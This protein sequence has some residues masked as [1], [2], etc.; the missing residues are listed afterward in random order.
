MIQVTH[1]KHD[2]TSTANT[3]LSN[4]SE[5]TNHVPGY[6]GQVIPKKDKHCLKEQSMAFIQLKNHTQLT[7]ENKT[8]NN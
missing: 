6:I 5:D 4:A 3:I 8:T 2:G 1:K 7:V